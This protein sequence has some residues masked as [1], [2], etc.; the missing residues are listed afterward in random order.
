MA[1]ATANDRTA[2]RPLQPF[3]VDHFRAYV[4]NFVLDD[5]SNWEPQ[6]FQ[7]DFAEDV[8]SDATEVWLILP[9]GNGK[10]TLLSGVALYHGD[11]TQDAAV[12]IGASS[13][14]QA[15]ILYRQ[16]VGFINRTPGLK[17]R[18]RTY[19]GYR[20][21][22]C[23]RTE[24]RIQVYAADDRTGDGIIPTLPLLEELHRHRDFRLYRTWRGKLDKR[25]G[26][27]AA[28]STAG[29]PG[30]EFEDI[31]LKHRSTA[32]KVEQTGAH[33]RAVGGGMVLHDY[34]VTSL[35]DVEDMDAVKAANPL[36]S[37][38][39]KSLAAKRKSPTMSLSHWKRFVCNIATRVE[40]DGI[41]PEDWDAL[42]EKDLVPNKDAWAIGFLDLGWK[43]DT[44]AM[45]VLLWESDSRRVIAGVKI[46]E[47]PVKEADIVPALVELQRKFQ[48][49]GWAYDPNAGGQQ[50]VE[51]LDTGRHPDQHGAEFT[52]LEHSQDNAPMSLAAAR[53]D[54]AIRGGWLVHDGDPDLRKH[55]LSAVR[56]PLGGDKYR[57]DRPPDAKG[58]RRKK[59]P[60]D[61]L[62]GLLFG[63][64]VAVAEHD[65]PKEP[66]AIWGASR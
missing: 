29:E 66:I 30:S 7:L 8:F 15:E 43:I 27:L 21:V 9:E 50:M 45:G 41:T 54:E 63:N 33:A 38:T 48:P 34:A 3:T 10:T 49:V 44:T 6:P 14:E 17:K 60:I 40:G 53:L 64:S 4:R 55:V 19:D 16:A 61:A 12:P 56:R 65:K 46:L 24:G 58:E 1:V 51:M 52:F 42:E 47:P 28:I 18:F 36:P 59:Y 23:L 25:G 22:K 13:R 2:H 57:F 62:T 20:R 39:P 26:T 37:I 5:G 31:R 32:E 35:D 11:Y